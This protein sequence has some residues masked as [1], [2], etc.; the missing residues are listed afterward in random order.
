MDN[1]GQ[2]SFSRMKRVLTPTGR[3][4]PNSGHGGM[5]HVIAAM[6][7][8]MFSKKVTGMRIA[9]LN[10]EDFELLAELLQNGDIKPIIDEVFP[11]EETARAIDALNEG[12]VKGKVV[13]AVR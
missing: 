1:I 9:K 10:R 11:F 3:L 12:D 6:L 7:H 5:I 8:G 13:V 4:V 2:V